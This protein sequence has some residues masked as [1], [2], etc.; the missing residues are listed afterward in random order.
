M[1]KIIKDNN[2][3]TREDSQNVGFVARALISASLPH[4]KPKGILYKRQCNNFTISVIGNEEVG[5]VPYGLYPRLI[6]SWLSTEVVKTKSREIILGKSLSDFMKNLGL[7]VTGGKFGTLSRFKDQI[8]RLFASTMTYTYHNTK[9]GSFVSTKISIA[10]KTK[11]F[12]DISSVE[13][14]FFNSKIFLGE[15][16]FNEIIENPI[17]VDM[18]AISLLKDSSLALDIY[19][20]LTYRMSYLKLPLTLSYDQLQSQ[21]G[22]GYTNTSHSKYEFKRKFLIQLNKVLH[23]YT[24][25]NV[26]MVD[27]GLLLSPSKTHIK[28]PK[29]NNEETLENGYKSQRKVIPSL[30]EVLKNTFAL[31]EKQIIHLMD[32]YSTEEIQKAIDYTNQK[33]NNTNQIKIN[34]V[35]SYILSLIKSGVKNEKISITDDQKLNTDIVKTFIKNIENQNEKLVLLAMLKKHG[36]DIFKSW[37]T[38]T[39]LLKQTKVSIFYICDNKFITQRLSSKYKGEFLIEWKKIDSAIEECIFVEAANKLN[40]DIY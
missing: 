9:T 15:E 12:W 8:C 33:L 30:K 20:W 6:L 2:L 39:K 18:K 11:I 3:L 38:R 21:F 7:S 40:Q 4:S 35:T 23:V 29:I 24:D 10:D 16:F 34:N 17:P 13:V 1:S 31:S 32:T 19:F 36:E 26:S 14:D 25:A 5:G 28:V 22:A 37:F 27:K